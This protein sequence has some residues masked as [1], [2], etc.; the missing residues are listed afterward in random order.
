M[1]LTLFYAPGACSLASHI[2]LEE[3]GADYTAKRI[4]FSQGEQRKPEFLSVNPKGRVPALVTDRGVLTEN[5]VI[6]GYIAQTFPDAKLAPNDDSFGFGD[7]QSFNMWI[8]STLHPTF[9]HMFR[10]ERYADGDEAQAAIRA[11]TPHALRD[12]FTLAETDLFK[13]PW[14]RGD[15]YT[16]AD[17]YLYVMESWLARMPGIELSEFPKLEDHFKRMSERPAVRRAREQEGLP[18]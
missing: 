8:A 11:K 3:A 12:L 7:L 2:A 1:T 10:P 13:G 5:P 6:L 4:D 9:A 16:I 18:V 17:P 15:A 14:V